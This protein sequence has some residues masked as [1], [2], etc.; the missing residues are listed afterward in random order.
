[1]KKNG[2]VPIIVLVI[3]ILGMVGYFAYKNLAIKQSASIT[4]PA[5]SSVSTNSTFGTIVS[6][7]NMP[8]E[9]KGVPIYPNTIYDPRD[10]YGM[11]DFYIAGWVC[12]DGILCKA[13]Y[14]YFLTYDDRAKVYSWYTSQTF[15]GWK[16]VNATSIVSDP[17]EYSL[18]YFGSRLVG[19]NKSYTLDI[20]SKCD[21][22]SDNQNSVTYTK[23]SLPFDWPVVSQSEI[24]SWK[25][26]T[27][28]DGSL[29]FKYPSNLCIKGDSNSCNGLTFDVSIDPNTGNYTSEQYAIKRGAEISS[30]A[31]AVAI[32]NKPTY[33][34]N[35]DFT[36]LGNL[37]GGGSPGPNVYIVRNGKIISIE[38]DSIGVE[39]VNKILSTLKFNN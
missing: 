12:G 19:D 8:T 24:G 26:F 31:D 22:C 25:T 17:A 39:Q 35:V 37:H 3:V 38:T 18:G 1:M 21:S 9:F 5:P 30:P 33:L 7:P 2:F 36:I 20:E 32:K 13:I 29:T 23:A 14:Y 4:S 28:Q 10:G 15:S 11:Q 16:F 34:T 27:S 6:I